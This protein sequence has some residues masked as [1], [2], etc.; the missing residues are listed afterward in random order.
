VRAVPKRAEGRQPAAQL[1]DRADRLA[2]PL[3]GGEHGLRVGTQG[4]CALGQHDAAPDALKERDAELRLEAA[5]L[6]GERRLREMQRLRRGRERAV[7]DRR[8]DVLQLLQGHR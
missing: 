7:L 6:L 1:A 4:A 5:H 8:E 2:R 3:G